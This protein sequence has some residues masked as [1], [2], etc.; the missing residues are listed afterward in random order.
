MSACSSAVRASHYRANS[1]VNSTSHAINRLLEDIPSVEYEQDS[2]VHSQFVI[3][4]NLGAK[5]D[6]TPPKMIG[7][8]DDAERKDE[9]APNRKSRAVQPFLPSRRSK[10]RS[11]S[12][13]PDTPTSEGGEAWDLEMRF[14][15]VEEVLFDKM[16]CEP[17]NLTHVPYGNLQPEMVVELVSD[18]C[19]IML[20]REIDSGYWDFP[21]REV[22]RD[23]RLCFIRFFDW[24]NLDYRDNR[25]VRVPVN[26]WPAQPEA[27]GKHALI[28]SL[29]VQFVPAPPAS[30]PKLGKCGSSFGGEAQTEVYAPNSLF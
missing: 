12:A 28:Q 17:V 24:D 9:A 21:L 3:A 13:P 22:T 29:D 19:P 25:Y 1:C 23:A 7:S 6:R 30:N 27:I 4:H 2:I 15:H 11:I 14:S 26:D 16:V 10:Q 18:H 20:N 5:Q 8:H